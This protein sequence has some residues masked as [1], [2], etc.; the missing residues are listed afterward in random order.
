MII[1]VL[2]GNSPDI[3]QAGLDL[4]LPGICDTMDKK[5]FISIA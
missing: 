2:K 1:N 4:V 5:Y 3:L